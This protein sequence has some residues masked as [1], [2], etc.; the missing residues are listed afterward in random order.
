MAGWEGIGYIP[1][2][3][4]HADPEPA[5]PPDASVDPSADRG[6]P[7]PPFRS[8]LTRVLL[9]QVLTLILLWLL[10]SRYGR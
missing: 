3:M 5:T 7:P 8:T 6:A 2:R 9:V 1:P 4:S 10:Q